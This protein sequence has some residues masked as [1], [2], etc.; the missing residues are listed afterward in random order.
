MHCW[1]SSLVSSRVLLARSA[2]REDSSRMIWRYCSRSSGVVSGSRSSSAKPLMA[3]M[4]V[5]NS[6][7]KWL[8]KSVRRVWMLWSYLDI[9]LKSS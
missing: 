9:L 8:M 2:R 4:G 6:W 1:D 3:V 5:L 7:E